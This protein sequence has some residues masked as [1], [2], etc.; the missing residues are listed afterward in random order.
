VR[1]DRRTTGTDGCAGACGLGG[2]LQGVG[3]GES[4][5]GL[6]DG[7]GCAGWRLGANP[8][9]R[10]PASVGATVSVPGTAV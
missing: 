5:A 7:D 2:G 8:E 9:A 1:P 6:E 4:L 10:A 3:G